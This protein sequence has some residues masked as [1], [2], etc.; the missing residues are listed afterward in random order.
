MNKT[1]EILNFIDEA[2]VELDRDYNILYLNTQ[3]ERLWQKKK[4]DL[5]GKNILELFK[6][7]AEIQGF[8]IIKKAV[9]GNKKASGSY[10]SMSAEKWL[11]VSAVPLHKIILVTIKDIQQ[12][13]EAATRIREEHFSLNKAQE[14]GHIGSFER[15]L[16]EG[17]KLYW[18]D[19]LY[20][21]HG[22]EPQSEDMTIEKAV[23]FVA[24]GD[25]SEMVNAIKQ[26]ETMG[27]SINII[28]KIIRRDGAERMV[29][30]T[31]E[32]LL[33]ENGKPF[34]I[35]GTIQDITE[36]YEAQ[37]KIKA[38][39]RLLREAELV[40]HTGSYEVDLPDFTIK[41]SEGMYTLLG[42]SPNSF[43]PSLKFIDS[44]SAP[45][46]VEVVTKIL[47][48]A[49]TTKKPYAYVK[50][51][52][53]PNGQMRY[54]TC[55]GVVICDEKGNALKILGTAQD[56]TEQ[57]LAEDELRE[58]KDLLK[59]IFDASTFAITVFKSHRN[60]KGEIV[61]FEY[62]L[63]NKKAKNF[64]KQARIGSTLLQL[65]PTATLHGIFDKYKKVIE[66]GRPLD[67]IEKFDSA[68]IK[69]WFR[70]TAVKMNNCLVSM[71]EDISDRYTA[72]EELKEQNHFIRQ[73]TE[74]TPDLISVFNIRAFT[75]SYMSP[76]V[77][78]LLG[79]TAS[80][81]LNFTS[82]DIR[83]QIHP[84]DLEAFENLINSFNQVEDDTVLELDYRVKNSNHI[85]VYLR[86]RT[87]IFLR[88]DDGK[89]SHIIAISQDISERKKAEKHLRE[90]AHFIKQI[91]QASPD[92]IT[93]FDLKSSSYIYINK[94][95][96]LLLGSTTEQVKEM[97]FE[98]VLNFIHPD[99]QVRMRNF[100]QNFK[101][102]IDNEILE[103]EY[104]VKNTHNEWSW[105]KARG[106]VFKRDA[107]G[108][109]LQVIAVVQDHT[110][111][112]EAEEKI[113][114]NELMQALLLKKDEFMGVASHE[115]K[116]P[117]T[118]IKASLQVLQRQIEKQAPV[119]VLLVFV[120][121]AIQ[122]INKLISMIGELMD[123]TKIQAGKMALK[124][125]PCTADEIIADT[126]LHSYEGIEIIVENEFPD[127][128]IA[129][130]IRIE[131][132]LTNFLTNAIKYSPDSKKVII[133]VRKSGNMVRFLVTD[134]GMG[135]PKDKLPYIFDRFFR[136]NEGTTQVAGLGL[137]LFISAEIIKQ[138]NGIYGVDSQLGKGST[139]WFEIPIKQ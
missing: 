58:K 16:E 126:I 9:A 76:Q 83:S 81:V 95:L 47:K 64:W 57:K 133:S 86:S 102:T 61:D 28:H 127:T 85:W 112:K 46:D 54:I 80:K 92:I 15:F 12:H 113:H 27:E 48:K 23:S 116:T 115:L 75:F 6:A 32:V 78:S 35:Y 18:S 43:V 138:H 106:K 72:E 88:G 1:Y 60:E 50:R 110:Q 108:E 41:F 123:N 109:V 38:S 122:Q 79:Y 89:V 51:I 105:F 137:G 134:F 99:D 53:R 52:F 136:I 31:A 87:K 59:A 104:R 36:Q 107:D 132:V 19:E 100:Y 21:I 4:E 93:I 11:N 33:D 17:S 114:E 77:Y 34:K 90:Q 119:N 120:T 121:R 49:A 125:E 13:K 55:K 63:E 26:L 94:E 139:F 44:I 74:A 69:G 82:E 129:D 45:E 56:I 10:Y 124:L 7:N 103:I 42:Y 101:E 98:N 65:F 8:D 84:D 2:C 29:R 96:D 3:A 68:K 131:Q 22:L 71:V 135:I 20:R 91:T 73:V 24:P 117:I 39:E 118:T 5:I 40:G 37:E 130:R 25:R 70:L 67:I 30:R 111:T 14:I 97:G 66:T 62:I 128:I